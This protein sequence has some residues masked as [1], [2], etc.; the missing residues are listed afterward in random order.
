MSKKIHSILLNKS[1]SHFDHIKKIIETNGAL[2]LEPSKEDLF[3]HM[4]RLVTNQQLSTKAARTIWLRIVKDIKKHSKYKTSL[5]I[6]KLNNLSSFGLSHNKTKAII[7]LKQ[8]FLDK[9]I[10]KEKILENTHP[11]ITQT[12]NN[13]WGFGDWSAD[14]IAMFYCG[15][16][17]IWSNGDLALNKGLTMLCKKENSTKEKILE[18]YKPHLS[19]LAL[20]IWKH[21]D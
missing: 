8:A 4:A 12:V 20:H 11:Q 1:K 17:N 9:Q 3:I 5:N 21:L 10:I 2:T 14:M 15:L 7:C 6:H 13:I 18:Y 19:Y 16:P